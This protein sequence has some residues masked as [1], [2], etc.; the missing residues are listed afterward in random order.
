M[1]NKV[2]VW[3]VVGVLV[4]FLAFGCCGTLLVVSSGSG[5]V[6]NRIALIHLTGV[7][8]ASSDGAPGSADPETL[9]G[10]LRRA[11]ADPAVRAILLRVNSPGGVAAASQ[12]V[13][14]EVARLDKPVIVSIADIGASGAYM[15]SAEA[16]KIV[17]APASEVGSIGVI[18]EVPDI[19]RLAD[20]W[21]VG[22]T[23]IKEGKYKDMGNP[24]RKLTPAEKRILQA[25]AKIT[26]DQFIEQ[27][28]KARKMPVAKVRQLATGRTWTGSEALQ[29]GLVDEMGNYQDAVD[30]AARLGR[31]KGRPNVVDYETPSLTNIV[32]QLASSSANAAAARALSVDGL[33]GRRPVR[34]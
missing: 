31:I 19:Q 24:F 6:K 2:V 30:L 1:K 9:I 8:A 23:V 15:I 34:Q 5:L 21:G 29:I 13:A 26:Y 32:N 27:I 14:M 11:D 4:L 33:A 12:E 7:I 28:A 17:A 3:V 22:M 18:M 16:D 25:D 10:E 20:K